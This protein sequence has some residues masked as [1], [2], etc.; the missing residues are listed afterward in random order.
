MVIVAISYVTRYLRSGFANAFFLEKIY[1]SE[2]KNKKKTKH[3]IYPNFFVK[4]EGWLG[5]VNGYRTCH[6]LKLRTLVEWPQTT[7][8][9]L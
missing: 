1:F 6:A 5:R 7:V 8:P 4:C 9:N 3:N 2:S